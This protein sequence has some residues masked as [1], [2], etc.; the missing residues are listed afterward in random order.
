MQ[1]GYRRDLWARQQDYVEVWTEKDAISSILYPITAKWDVP[2]MTARDSSL[3]FLLA[4]VAEDLKQIGKPSYL[5]YFGDH[6]PSG[7]EC[8]AGSGRDY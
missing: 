8:A 1:N 4:P 7:K 2:L 5:Y 6:D 3:L